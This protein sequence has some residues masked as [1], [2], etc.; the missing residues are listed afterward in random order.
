MTTYY[1]IFRSFRDQ[2]VSPMV[3]RG[4]TLQQAQ[5]HCHDLETSSSTCTQKEGLDRTRLHGPWFDGYEE[6]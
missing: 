6:E 2:D 5:A 3:K 4:L 1:K